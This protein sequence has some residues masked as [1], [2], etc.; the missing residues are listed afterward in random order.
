MNETEFNAKLTAMIFVANDA[1]VRLMNALGVIGQKLGT[2]PTTQ[3]PKTASRPSSS[4]SSSITPPPNAALLAQRADLLRR[5]EGMMQ[6]LKAMA[7]AAETMA[8]AQTPTK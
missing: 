3:T 1:T 8:A 5:M 7:G 2:I 4:S 6:E